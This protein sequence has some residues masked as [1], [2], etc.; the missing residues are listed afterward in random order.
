MKILIVDLL[1]IGDLLFTT[2]VI[3]AL[4]TA[5][6]DA[7]LDMVVNQTSQAVIQHNPLINN[8]IGMNTKGT[9]SLRDYLRILK[10]LRREKYDLAIC[11]HGHNERATLITGLSGAKR[12]CG[13]AFPAL[14]WLYDQPITKVPSVHPSDTYLWILK[15]C[16]IPYGPHQ[17]L[18]MWADKSSR[19]RGDVLWHDA[20]L[21]GERQVIG[22]NPGASFPTKRWTI[23]GFAALH[24]RLHADGY[25]PVFFGGPMDVE[26]VTQISAR[27]ATP[28]ITFTGKVN[29]SELS[30]LI[31]KCACFVSGDSGPMHMAASQQVPTL[32]IFG[33]T[34][35]ERYYPY[36]VPHLVVTADEPCLR[37]EQRQCEDLRCMKN[38]TVERVYEGV[39]TLMRENPTRVLDGDQQT[40]CIV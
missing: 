21:T 3:R 25:V 10:R 22:I 14:R 16:G 8:I 5:H 4:R 28:P 19:Q 26:M 7:Q 38:L 34:I 29:L 11:L 2:P 36:G 12:T 6:P 9:G 18:E 31:R 20:G 15:E 27:T 37:C 30:V 24:D 40:P 39:R 17:G 35:S 32:A 33:P 1:Y 13:Q 23:D